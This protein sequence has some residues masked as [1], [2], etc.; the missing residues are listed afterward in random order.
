MSMFAVPLIEYKKKQTIDNTFASNRIMPK[1]F[2]YE[3]IT[4]ISNHFVT[5]FLMPKS[6]VLFDLNRSDG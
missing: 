2:R 3:S 5:L 4:G 1:L 6:N